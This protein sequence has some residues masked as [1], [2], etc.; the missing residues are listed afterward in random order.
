MH[1]LKRSDNIMVERCSNQI[2]GEG[3]KRVG[4]TIVKVN[5]KIIK[6]PEYGIKPKFIDMVVGREAKKDI[7]EDEWVT[8]D[9][10]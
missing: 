1:L 8:W 4:K 7:K 5:E 3:A 2:D 10:V 6:R 9:A